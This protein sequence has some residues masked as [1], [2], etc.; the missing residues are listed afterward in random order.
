MGG[1]GAELEIP[2]RQSQYERIIE[3]S[4]LV[5]NKN[6]TCTLK[7][8]KVLMLIWNTSEL[9]LAKRTISH[10]CKIWTRIWSS[11]LRDIVSQYFI[12]LIGVWMEFSKNKFVK[13]CKV[14]GCKY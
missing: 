7:V 8:Y 1:A 6:Y 12:T 11:T 2:P 14:Q 10:I 4:N 9:S 3:Q 13:F 5:Q